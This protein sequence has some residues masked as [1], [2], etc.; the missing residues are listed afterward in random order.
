MINLILD[1]L[2]VFFSG[3]LILIRDTS[4]THLLFVFISLVLMPPFMN[5]NPI[6]LLPL[7]VTV[8]SPVSLLTLRVSCYY[9]LETT[10]SEIV[11][12]N[13]L[14]LRLLPHLVIRLLTLTLFTLFCS[15]VSILVHPISQFVSYGH[16]SLALFAF[17]TS[18]SSVV[19][20]KSVQEAT[21]IPS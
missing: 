6:F 1:Q 7:V 11:V 13:N 10:P 4:V 9:S 3:I 14:Q 17:T 20:P 12:R 15:K 18:V 2:N 16:L 21:S 5:L 19:V 8:L